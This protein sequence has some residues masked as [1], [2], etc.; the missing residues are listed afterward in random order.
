MIGYLTTQQ[1]DRLKQHKYSVAGRSLIEVYMQPFWCWLVD[2]MPLWLAPNLITFL[3]LM[4]NVMTTLI[5][6][7]CCPHM[8][9]EVSVII[10]FPV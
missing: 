8:T 5:L 10:H 1:L 3:G 9:E 7:Y 4:V 2:Q 6:A